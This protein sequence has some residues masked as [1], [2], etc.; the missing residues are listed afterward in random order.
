MV[1][2]ERKYEY[3][4]ILRERLLKQKDVERAALSDSFSARVEQLEQLMEAMRFNDR[5][6]LLDKIA[7]WKKNY[8][9]VCTEREEIEESYK[10][11][12]D[13]KEQ[14]LQQML[15][16]NDEERQKTE[17]AKEEGVEKLAEQEKKWK[18]LAQQWASDKETLEHHIEQMEFDAQQ[19]QQQLNRQM[20]LEGNRP[21]EDPALAPLRAKIAELEE[22]LKIVEEGKAAII[23]ENAKLSVH[24]DTVDTQI[25]D[26]HAIYKPKLEAK[27]REIKMMEKRHDELKEILALEMK[28]AQDTCANIEEQVKR[29]P[30]PFEM[31]IQEMKD[32]YAQMQAGMQKIQME[33]LRLEQQCEKTRVDLEKE[34]AG[35]EKA[36]DLAKHLLTEVA[37]LDALKHLE[38]GEAHQLEGLLGIDLDKDGKIG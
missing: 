38:K 8:S 36:L 31:E 6:E 32:K 2:L 16:E 19:L 29:F 1:R 5:E 25:E 24:T 14:Q 12:M 21:K 28:R 15:I 34:I 9:R 13:R 11:L 27:D 4:Q 7:L 26:V 35:L 10:A 17:K 3:E 23:A 37:T 18:L 33:N 20:F 22:Q 30:E